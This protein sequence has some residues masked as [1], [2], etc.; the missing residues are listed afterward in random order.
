MKRAEL[1]FNIVSIPVDIISLFVAGMASLYIRIKLDPFIPVMSL[2]TL[3]DYLSLL[4]WVIPCM[5]FIF[6]F[7]GLYNLRG[8]RKFSK[9]LLG[10]IGSI[11]V[12]LFVVI[13]VFFFDQRL[14]PSRLV[15]LTAWILAIFFV[16]FGRFIL[17]QIQTHLL[18]KGFGLHRLVIVTDRT[19]ELP[20]IEHIE[21]HPSTG[22][23]VIAKLPHS[24]DLLDKLEELYRD[25]GLEEILHI[26]S[27]SGHDDSLK[28]VQFARAKGLNFNYVPNLYDVQKNI[29]DTETI[30][31]TP[32]ISLKNTPLVG[33]GA[34]IKRI[35]D[36]I[37]A[38]ICLIIT[39]PLSLIIVLVIKLNSPGPIFYAVKRGG[40][41]KD[42]I[43]YKFR[44]MYTHL[45]P[46]EGYGGAE[47]KKLWEELAEKSNI[48]D[49]SPI[50]KIKDDPRVT[51]VGKFLRKSKLDEI[52]QFIN[53]LRGDMSMVGPRAHVLEELE[54]YRDD[55]RRLFTI[56]P[57]I[58]GLA[59]IAQM[60]WPELP[61]EEEVRLNTFYIEN[62][63]LW[64]DIKTL[65]KSFYYLFFKQRK[66]PNT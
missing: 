28:L 18:A 15:I 30:Q 3:E 5:L 64:L 32:V 33:W 54:K 7:A 51:P 53:V 63:S 35:F 29:V 17:K 24:G 23:K 56:K 61:F 58:F 27:T 12:A 65:A 19:T 9:E 1:I 6:G 40:M 21:N 2:P 4:S 45:S 26:S 48:R 31:G 57:G 34:V 11:T 50:P 43:F 59:Q 44:S 13:L 38:F 47:A 14:F 66:D 42:F 39:L 46:G 25:E 52:P 8:T 36:V 37:T 16:V 60:D 22:Y 41:G 62:W 20:L 10:I 55:H 49:G